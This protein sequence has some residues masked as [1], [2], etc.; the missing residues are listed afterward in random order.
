MTGTMKITRLTLQQRI[1]NASIILLTVAGLA[2]CG[3]SKDKKS[4]QSLASVNGEE[5]TAL[6]L[7]EELQRAGVTAAQQA[8]ASKQLLEALIDRQIVLNEAEKQK[9]DRDPKVMQAIER[10]KAMII[11]QTYMQKKLGGLT[12]PTSTDVEAYFTKHPELFSERK[13]FD[14]RQLLIA[15]KDMNGG[16]KEVIDKSRTL[17]EVAAWMD[18]N[19]IGYTRAQVSRATTDLAPELATKL[20]SMPKGQLFIVNEGER[21]MLI[22]IVDV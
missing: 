2:A 18:V 19:R 21:S 14:M 6:Q 8:T 22:T 15:S 12:K 20:L 7:N 16:V 4:S 1:L 5:I 13:Q 17:D 3:G 10:A 9:I 11:S